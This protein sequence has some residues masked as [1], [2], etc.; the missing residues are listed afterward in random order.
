MSGK[1][2]D[3]QAG[4][5]EVNKYAEYIPCFAR[6]LNLV[7][8]CAAECCIEASIFFDFVESLYTFFFAS[9]YRWSILTKALED[10]GSKLPTLK[11]LSDTRCSARA[12]AT[13]ALLCGITTIKQVLDDISITWIKR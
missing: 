10:T 1:Y 4:I 7:A 9:T 13:K 6:S 11:R 5:K 3:L 12:H 2:H 8:K